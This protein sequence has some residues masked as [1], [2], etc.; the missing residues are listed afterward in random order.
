MGR[1]V[2]GRHLPFTLIELLC[3][4]MLSRKDFFFP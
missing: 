4:K 3:L 2:G 1:E